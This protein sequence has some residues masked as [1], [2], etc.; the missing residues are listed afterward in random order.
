MT[1][2]ERFDQQMNASWRGLYEDTC[3]IA[4]LECKRGCNGREVDPTRC[5]VCYARYFKEVLER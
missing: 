1:P 2:D 3:A 5:M 4:T